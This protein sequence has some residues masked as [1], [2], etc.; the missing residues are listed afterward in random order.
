[1]EDA[2]LTTI[3][4]QVHDLQAMTEFY[5]AA[6][7]AEFRPVTTMGLDSQFGR[8]GAIELK[9]VPLR[10]APDFEGYPSH[11]L[12]FAVDDVERVIGLATK[13]GGRQEGEIR[14]EGGRVHAAV[15]DPDGNTLELYAG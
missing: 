5:A 14:T 9:L 8:V 7:G 4:I 1:M 13:H 2:L 11:Q 6:F 10:A 12:G 3:A 15:R